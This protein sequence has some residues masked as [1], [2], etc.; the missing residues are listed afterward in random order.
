MR[1]AQ[2][3]KYQMLLRLAQC[4]HQTGQEWPV[5]ESLPARLVW[6]AHTLTDR[7]TVLNDVAQGYEANV[8]FLKIAVRML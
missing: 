2:D 7:T 6:G 8:F 1:L 5:G 4:L 3:H